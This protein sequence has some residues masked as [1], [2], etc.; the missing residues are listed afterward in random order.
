MSGIALLLLAGAT[1]GAEGFA[2]TATPPALNSGSVNDPHVTAPVTLI[3]TGG[4]GSY[5]YA[6]TLT[7]DPGG[8]TIVSPTSATTVFSIDTNIG[9]VVDATARGTVTDTVTLAP[10]FVDVPI[11]HVDFR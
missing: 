11:H 5:T 8:I 4:S 2:V 6:W 1:V 3:P 7:L 10:A 9:D